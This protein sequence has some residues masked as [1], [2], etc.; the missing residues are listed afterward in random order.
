MKNSMEIRLK[1]ENEPTI[2]QR[3]I[4]WFNGGVKP[5]GQPAQQ[6]PKTGTNTEILLSQYEQKKLKEAVDFRP[7]ERN[8]D[9]SFYR[10]SDEGSSLII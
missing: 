10:K 4:C 5:A 6:V 9:T 7:F 1:E 2:W 8:S 3:F